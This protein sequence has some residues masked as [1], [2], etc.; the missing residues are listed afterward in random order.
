M[1]ASGCST[2]GWPAPDWSQ[3]WNAP[4]ADDGAVVRAACERGVPLPQA[5]TQHLGGGG[6]RFVPQTD[7]PEGMAY[8]RFIFDHGAVPTRDGLHDFFNGLCWLR[9]P[10][11]KLQLNRLQGAE[12]A[13]QGVSATRGP[14]R[15]AL[16][17]FDEIA[18]L[19]QAPDALW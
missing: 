16:T 17:L 13:Q 11:S 9:F 18:A 15:D 19:L 2:A 8:E 6:P 10:Q 3:P 5:L 7:L 12:I 4:F 1:C 14:V